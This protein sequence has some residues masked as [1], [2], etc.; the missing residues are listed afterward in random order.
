LPKSAVALL[1]DVL[2]DEEAR[3]P[4]FGMDNALR[5]P[6][7]VAAKTGTSRA[8]VDNW[9]VGFT[10][11]RTVAVWA[12]NFDGVPMHKVSGISGAGPIFARILAL[13][14]RGLT[15]RP[16]VQRGRFQHVLVCALSGQRATAH[17]PSAVEEVFLPGT[18][19]HDDCHMHRESGV[20]PAR[21]RVLDV[22]PDFYAWARTQG[23]QAG[24]WPDEAP[25]GG[26]AELL[27]PEDGDE[28]LLE[29]DVPRSAQSIPVRVRPPPGAQRL[30]L[31]TEDGAIVPLLPPFTGQLPARA[32]RHRVEVWAPGGAVALASAQYLVRGAER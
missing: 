7:P 23:W 18:A 5:L 20:G 4:A 32:G 2:S 31:R 11:E 27:T 26:A 16:L 22:G 1:T 21:H 10:A 6:F 28:Y 19:P 12:G 9:T 29:A 8:Y 13:S 15:P 17:C 24:P 30:E 3:V 25:T 14:M